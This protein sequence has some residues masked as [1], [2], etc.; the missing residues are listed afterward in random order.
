MDCPCIRMCDVELMSY[1]HQC[2][3][4][5]S[6]GDDWIVIL[7]AGVPLFSARLVQIP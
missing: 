5:Y 2:D 7:P 6:A 4:V 1:S 3:G